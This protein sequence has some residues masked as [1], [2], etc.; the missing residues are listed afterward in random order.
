MD[1]T[2]PE[3]KVIHNYHLGSLRM[4]GNIYQTDSGKDYMQGEEATNSL[5]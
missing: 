2:D 1:L 5:M 4:L 3:A